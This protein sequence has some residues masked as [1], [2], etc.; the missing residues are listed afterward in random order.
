[1]TFIKKEKMKVLMKSKKYRYLLII[2]SLIVTVSFFSFDQKQDSEEP[3]N[4]NQIPPLVQK[5]LDIKIK[6]YQQII[7]DKCRTKALEA[8]GILY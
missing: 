7:L 8:A 1:M 4:K 3:S 5:E 6:K 2:I